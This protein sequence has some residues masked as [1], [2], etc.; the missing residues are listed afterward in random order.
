MRATLNHQVF[1]N[2]RRDS[3]YNFEISQITNVL[4]FLLYARII[5]AHSLVLRPLY[6][7]GARFLPRRN[8]GLVSTVLRMCQLKTN[9]YN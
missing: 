2:T 1:V 3:S 6:A 8:K 5:Y 4:F 7:R 9:E